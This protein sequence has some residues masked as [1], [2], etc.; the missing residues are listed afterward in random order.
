MLGG[1]RYHINDKSFLELRV[2]NDKFSSVTASSA[3]V[4]NGG[5]VKS[6]NTIGTVLTVGGYL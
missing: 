1:I 4:L 5:I 3:G 6:H 2:Q